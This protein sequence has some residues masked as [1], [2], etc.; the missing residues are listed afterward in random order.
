MLARIHPGYKLST[1]ILANSVRLVQSWTLFY[2]SAVIPAAS[3]PTSAT[4]ASTSARWLLLIHQIPRK[5]DY[6]RVKIGRRLERVGAVAIKNSIYVL[7]FSTQAVEDFQWVLREIADGGGEASICRAE[8]VDGL[9]DAEIEQLLRE[10]RARD[11]EEIGR[12]ARVLL[13]RLPAGKVASEE[14]RA[15]IEL[16]LTRIR[17]RLEAVSR[18]DFFDA[19]ASSSAVSL[20]QSIEERLR[21]PRAAELTQT[22]ATP[23]SEMHNRVWVTREGIFVDRI[24]SAWLIRRFI[25]PK[26]TF[27]FVSARG[28]RPQPGEL[29]F[30]MFEAEYTHEGDRCTFETL[31]R[32]FELEDPAL[33][34]IAEIVHDIDLRDGKFER[35]DAR[36]IERV[37]AG[38]AA[39]YGDDASRLERGA[40]LFDELYALATKERARTRA[41]R[42]ESRTAT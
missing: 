18:I 17:A 5:P 1:P 38:I 25:D 22:S 33:S 14:R 23:R 21:P 3:M 9:T 41:L 20:V 34:E 26:A 13:R 30:D 31:V 29:R 10:A 15:R 2:D 28:Y 8:F 40:V 6:L 12:R 27:R 36:G 24:A 35:D 19:R 7:P 11:Y 16:E 4:D 39:A 37:L 32:R 42:E